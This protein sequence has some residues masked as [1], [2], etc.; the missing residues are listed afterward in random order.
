MFCLLFCFL[1]YRYSELTLLRKGCLAR[2]MKGLV[3]TVM[4]HQSSAS[5]YD[6]DCDRESGKTHTGYPC[7]AQGGS[8]Q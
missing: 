3:T 2:L 5:I 8:N 1:F 6:D 4:Q 7:S